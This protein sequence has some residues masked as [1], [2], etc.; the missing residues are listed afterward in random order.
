[1]S[2]FGLFCG[3]LLAPISVRALPAL[4]SR[5]IIT[6]LTNTTI[7]T[8]SPYTYYASA[9]YCEPSKV[10]AWNCGAECEANAQFKPVASG[11]DGAAVQYWFAGYD[12]SLDTVIVSHQGTDPGRIL[13]LITDADFSLAKL[14]PSLFPSIS[15]SVEVHNGFKEA[16]ARTA[17]DILA[18]VNSTLTK[19]NTTTVTVLGHSLGAAIALLDSV[20]LVQHLPSEITIKTIG[21]GLPRVGNQA[22][23]DYVDT[24]LRLT[25]I[26]NRQDP[27]PT[28][29]GQFMGYAQPSGE[30]HIES[31]GEWASCPG[32]DNPS[33]QCSYGAV[34]TVFD[35]NMENHNGP[36]NGI[37]MTYC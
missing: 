2:F 8:Y 4:V 36:Y 5:Q 28:C 17:T 9:G 10:M 15:T 27:I 26:N 33:S 35:G 23:A 25:H 7:D 14:D 6:T 11:G 18:A 1:M 22:F 32:Q 20:Y 12:P 24:N 30:L 31:S 3:F 19:Y 37:W 34:P 13:P 21:Y 29:P 16:Q